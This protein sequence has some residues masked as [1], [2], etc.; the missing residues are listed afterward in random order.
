MSDDD[1]TKAKVSVSM[2]DELQ[3]R[4]DRYAKDH[5]MTFSQV[6]QNALE[7]FLSTDQPIPPPPPVI[8]PPAPP[9]PTPLPTTDLV[10]RDYVKQLTI[11]VEV[12][13]RSMQ[14]AMM[15]VPPALPVPPWYRSGSEQWPPLDV[16]HETDL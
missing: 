13:R 15:V 3:Q 4:A 14:N 9:T 6:V 7:Q 16:S 8:P 11:Q 12:M 1:S 10:V 2:S 5:Q